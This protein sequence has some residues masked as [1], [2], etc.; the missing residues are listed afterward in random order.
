MNRYSAF[1]GCCQIGPILGHDG[2]ECRVQVYGNG[3]VGCVSCGRTYP[4]LSAETVQAVKALLEAHPRFPFCEAPH[5]HDLGLS[6]KYDEYGHVSAQLSW[7]HE[8]DLA[9]AQN[10]DDNV[11]WLF[12]PGQLGNVPEPL[13]KAAQNLCAAGFRVV[14]PNVGDRQTREYW[15]SKEMRTISLIR[16]NHPVPGKPALHGL[17][18]QLTFIV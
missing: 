17:H 1:R 4:Q 3:R 13:I 9:A 16:G 7:Y 12:E 2:D 11:G 8:H 5:V 6:V 18:A 14:A 15:F 10:P